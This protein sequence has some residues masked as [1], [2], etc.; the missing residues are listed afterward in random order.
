MTHIRISYVIPVAL[1]AMRLMS[2]GEDVSIYPKVIT[3]FPELPTAS[4]TGTVV[5]A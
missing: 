1:N 4:G 5:A 3:S 2:I